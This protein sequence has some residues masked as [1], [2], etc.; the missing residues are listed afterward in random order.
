METTYESEIQLGLLFK[1]LA[2]A[3]A[4]L[5]RVVDPAKEQQEL[6]EVTVKL[7]DGKLCVFKLL[8]AC[9]P[10]QLCNAHVLLRMPPA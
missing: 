3:F 9:M 6:K 5:E 4:R 2:A 7:Q 8:A 10:W 1:S